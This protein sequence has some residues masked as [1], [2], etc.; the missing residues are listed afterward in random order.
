MKKEIVAGIYL[1]S[2]FIIAIILMIVQPINGS[3]IWNFVLFVG[4]II[5]VWETRGIWKKL[6]KTRTSNH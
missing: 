4:A 6:K 1:S 3:N 5:I 2:A